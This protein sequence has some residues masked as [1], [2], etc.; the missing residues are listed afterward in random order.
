M[1]AL[2]DD[3]TTVAIDS[4]Q[5]ATVS[6]H[7]SGETLGEGDAQ[8]RGCEPRAK[9]ATVSKRANLER[10]LG[11]GRVEAQAR[12]P[13]SNLG[14][15]RPGLVRLSVAKQVGHHQHRPWWDKEKKKIR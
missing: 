14:G 6:T 8:A 11:R 3:R 5:S 12:Q 7:T 4:R 9:G 15:N 13:G 2:P 1:P 10:G